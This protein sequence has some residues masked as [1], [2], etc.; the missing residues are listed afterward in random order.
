[1][2]PW[3]HTFRIAHLNI[4]IE[5]DASACRTTVGNLTILFAP[6][7]DHG[8]PD[9]CFRLTQQST[10]QIALD[11]NNTRLWQSADAGEAVAALEWHLYGESVRRL[12]PELVSLHAAAVSC[13]SAS[14]AALLIAGH[15]GAG[16]SSLATCALLAGCRYLSDEF[17]LLDE[18]EGIHP[19]PR[20]LQWD[21]NRH[22]AFRHDRLTAGGL[23]RKRRYRFPDA[24]GRMRTSLLWLPANVEHQPLPAAAVVLPHFDRQVRSP[25]LEPVPRSQ[26]LIEMAHEAHQDIPVRQT[27]AELHRR[28]PAQILCYR[29][30][31]GDVHAAWR[32]LDQEVLIPLAAPTK[33]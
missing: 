24:E 7:C 33:G 16:K 4:R 13:G 8:E 29:L 22:P 12:A 3:R 28:L 2:T 30:S 15:S 25:R 14:R 1:M 27:I 31:F 21:R 20:P 19:F 17:S 9:L 11:L 18:R 32:L 23:F 6:A 26:V 5:G 10:G